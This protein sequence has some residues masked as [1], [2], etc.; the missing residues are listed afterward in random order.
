M[1]EAGLGVWGRQGEPRCVWGGREV[2][3]TRSVLGGEV[4]VD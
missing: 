3:E 4:P 2:G 1:S